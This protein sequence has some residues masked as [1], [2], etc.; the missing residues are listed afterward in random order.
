MPQTKTELKPIWFH[1]CRTTICQAYNTTF[2]QELK[3]K[4]SCM[5]FSATCTYLELQSF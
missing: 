4:R 5:I 3:F 1:K 2:V